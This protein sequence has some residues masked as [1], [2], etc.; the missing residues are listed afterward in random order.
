MRDRNERRNPLQGAG[1]IALASDGQTGMTVALLYDYSLISEEH[2]APVMLAARRI[3]T[4]AEQTK[5]SILVI[6]REL[7][8]VKARLAHGQFGDWLQREFDMSD[9]SARRFMAVYETFGGKSDTVSVL[10]DSAMLLLSAPS[11]SEE[12]RIEVVEIATT[13][14]KSPTK[15]AVQAVIESHKPPPPPRTLTP[16][17]TQAVIARVAQGV[18]GDRLRAMQ[19]YIMAHSRFDDPGYTS[20]LQPGVV[21]GQIEFGI[22]WDT[23]CAEIAERMGAAMRRSAPVAPQADA[24]TARS[25]ATMAEFMGNTAP[26]S[27][28]Q[29]VRMMRAIFTSALASLP[30]YSR[31]VG[32]YVTP[33]QARRVL[34]EML[35]KLETP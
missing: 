8:E 11:V 16:I 5:R 31:L 35:A 27:R 33:N 17:E 30:D 24:T 18:C 34:G 3:K 19:A 22:A 1:E 6:G 23:I 25:G 4:S 21:I 14:G 2:R 26:G 12:A 13:T 32:D 28:E 7:S 20:A 9:R 15:A 10:S 29:E